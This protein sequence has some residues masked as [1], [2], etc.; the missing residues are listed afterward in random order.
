M[1]TIAIVAAEHLAAL[2]AVGALASLRR[3]CPT[4]ARAHLRQ[5][6]GRAPAVAERRQLVTAIRNAA[7][8]QARSMLTEAEVLSDPGY[9][10][11]DVDA[12]ERALYADDEAEP[13]YECGFCGDGGTLVFRDEEGMPE[14]E[15]CHCTFTRKAAA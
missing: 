12:L 8:S 11:I 14:R 4:D 7:R 9:F 15:P 5:E 6:L 10:G 13:V 3:G 2:G 1:D